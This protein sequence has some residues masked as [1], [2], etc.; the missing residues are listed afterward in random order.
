MEGRYMTEVTRSGDVTIT[1]V[2]AT[3]DKAEFISF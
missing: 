2:E 1:A 3:K